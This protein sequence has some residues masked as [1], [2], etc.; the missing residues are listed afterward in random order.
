M[1]PRWLVLWSLALWAPAEWSAADG[2]APQARGAALP[3][4]LA[5]AGTEPSRG[6]LLYD[7]HCVACHDTQVHWR[8][9]RA[10]TD[11]RSLKAQVRRWQARALLDWSEADIVQVTR[12]LNDRIY[13]FAQTD[14]LVG[15]AR[16]QGSAR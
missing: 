8:D 7:T 15:L 9:A 1:R 11:W 10:V 6:Q 4:V 3:P 5:Q 2:Q 16:G 13:R 12:Y 14:D